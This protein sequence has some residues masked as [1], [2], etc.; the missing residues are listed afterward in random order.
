M[1]HDH[2]H[3]HAAPDAVTD[4]SQTRLILSIVLN[5]IITVA[6]V[7]GGLLSGSLALL[8]DA[9]HNF[10]DT[11][12]L[13]ISLAARRIAGRAPNWQKTFGYR[14]AE[15]IGAFV[16]LVT[17]VLIALYLMKEATE[18]L[19]SPRPIDGTIML[20]VAVIGLAANLIT[21]GLLHR[22][23]EGSLNIQSAFVHIVSDALSSVGV[24]LGGVLIL[25]YDVYF[26]DPILTFAIAC[27]ILYHSYAMLRRTIDI[28]M[29]SPPPA[30]HVP[31]VV[32]A[33]EALEAVRDMHHV[34]VWQID[35]QTTALEAH[36]AIEKA[37]L[38][39]MES[40]KRTIKERLR[41]DFGIG[42]STLEFEF[43]P[44]AEPPAADCLEHQQTIV[45]PPASS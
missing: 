40:L 28:L 18:R 39:Q 11:A 27:Y 6:E 5:L 35:E 12:S 10:G 34:H 3:S 8:S 23:V 16:N 22:D 7:I 36:I 17:L 19:V 37:D 24:V 13:G 20:V 31:D 15:L 9:L 32:E 2:A 29:E 41:A 42:H 44:C 33:V 21:A 1:A 30:L 4:G 38:D 26:V 14:R 45:P 25:A 43:A